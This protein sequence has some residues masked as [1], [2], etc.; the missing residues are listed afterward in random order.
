MAL[1]LEML[2]AELMSVGLTGGF[3]HVYLVRLMQA[4]HGS[5]V[6]VLKRVAVP[7]KEALGGMRTEVE[8][9]VRPAVLPLFSHVSEAQKCAEKIEGS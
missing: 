5:D 8:T 1:R 6:A 2:S 9:M 3:A 4:V 7:D